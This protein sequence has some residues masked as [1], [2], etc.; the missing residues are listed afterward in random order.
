MNVKKC[1]EAVPKNQKKHTK[2]A[3]KDTQK[4][5][6]KP[7]GLRAFCCYGRVFPAAV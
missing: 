1:T 2:P 6:R 3:A 4:K 7:Y 5:A